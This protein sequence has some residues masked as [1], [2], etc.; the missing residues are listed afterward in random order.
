MRIQARIPLPPRFVAAIDP[1]RRRLCP[2]H[3]RGN[4]A[5]VTLVY[6]DEAPER[7]LLR[8]RL[9]CA[10]ARTARFELAL[11]GVRRFEPPVSGACFAV[12]DPTGAVAALRDALLAP[13]FSAR[14]R[15]WPHVTLVHPREAEH[16][17]AA[18]P[19]LAAL[20][21]PGRF[22]VDVLELVDAAR[23]VVS[24]F[25]LAGATPHGARRAPRS[26]DT[27]GCRDS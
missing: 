21:P 2:A 3:A 27:G 18:W 6:E 15:F 17:E 22:D 19:E 24:R 4:P 20:A 13:P 25:P 8:E 9:R 26:H 5:H 14:K 23:N 10:A 12:A 11:V 16:L 1:I 7:L